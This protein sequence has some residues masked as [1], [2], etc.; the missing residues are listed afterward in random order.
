MIDAKTKTVV[1]ECAFKHEFLERRTVRMLW[2]PSHPFESQPITNSSISEGLMRIFIFYFHISN[3]RLTLTGQ[4]STSSASNSELVNHQ[5]ESPPAWAAGWFLLWN[6][7]VYH[8][9][10]LDDCI[11]DK[12]FGEITT[13]SFT[14]IWIMQSLIPQ[15]P[16]EANSSQLTWKQYY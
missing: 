8:L 4:K 11:T 9:L 5:L 6:L 3:L 15:Y 12:F 13:V 7:G 14:V 16:E 1:K 2:L 10:L